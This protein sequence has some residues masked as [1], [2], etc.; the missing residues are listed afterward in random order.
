M[1][2]KFKCIS[3]NEWDEGNPA[4]MDLACILLCSSPY[5]TLQ[6]WDTIKIKRDYMFVGKHE[7]VHHVYYKT[8]SSDLM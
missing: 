2:V 8:L 4:L 6:W 7:D 5:I 1:R 3:A